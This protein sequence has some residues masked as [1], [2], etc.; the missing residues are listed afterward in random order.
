MK[1]SNLIHEYLMHAVYFAPRGRRRIHELGADITQRYLSA[2]DLLIGV[3][4]DAGAGKSLLIQG[5]F[6]GLE[7]SND[8]QGINVRPLPLL[9]H[10]ENDNFEHHTYHIDMLFEL[11]FTQLSVLAEAVRKAMQD[12]CRV[13]VEHFELLYPQLNMNAHVLVGIGEEVIIARPGIFGPLPEQIKS[14]VYKSLAYRKMAH[15]AEDITQKVLERMGVPQAGDHDDIRRGFM[16][17]YPPPK[18]PHAD[19]SLV[20]ELVK[21]IIAK[22][23]T[24][25]P[26]GNWRIKFGDMKMR[27]TGPRI[28]VRSTGEIENFRLIKN[29]IRDPQSGG[30]RIVGLVGDE[31]TGEDVLGA[32]PAASE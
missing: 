29:Y 27:C 19:L 2:E 30:Y 9:N 12:G 1:M 14:I 8:D 23:L 5:M 7:L 16:L 24:I 17:C 6:P 22:D 4:G 10:A 20:E 28:H 32:I 18:Q 21:E 31:F 11:A 3:V 15:T 26:E 13:V 25:V